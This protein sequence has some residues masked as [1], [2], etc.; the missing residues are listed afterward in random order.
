VSILDEL[1]SSIDNGIEDV[2]DRYED[3]RFFQA[4]KHGEH[5]SYRNFE[6]NGEKF[7]LILEKY[8]DD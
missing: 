6:I 4:S 3:R 1:T 5:V 7:T 8:Q 2:M